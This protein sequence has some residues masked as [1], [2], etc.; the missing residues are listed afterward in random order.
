MSTVKSD[1]MFEETSNSSLDYDFFK[2]LLT[3]RLEA[4]TTREVAIRHDVRRGLNSDSAE[5]AVELENADV[6]NAL[7]DGAMSQIEEINFALARL[8]NGTYGVCEGCGQSIPEARLKA[9]PHSAQCTSCADTDS[10]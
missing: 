4:L 3:E 8:E 9:Y 6:L 2:N 1:K 5:R 7:S 10:A